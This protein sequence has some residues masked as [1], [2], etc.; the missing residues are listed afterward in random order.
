VSTQSSLRAE[1]ELADR[2]SA[3]LLALR[4]LLDRTAPHGRGVPSDTWREARRV[5][6]DNKHYCKER[7]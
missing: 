2:L 6:E 4:K 5:Y 1:H 3:T 7:R